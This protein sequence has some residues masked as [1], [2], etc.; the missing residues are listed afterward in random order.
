MT[1]LEDNRTIL[2]ARFVDLFWLACLLLLMFSAAIQKYTG[3][4]YVDEGVTCCLAA[5]AVYHVFSAWAHRELYVTPLAFVAAF[6]LILLAALGLFSN[7][8][9]NYNTNLFDICI[10]LFTCLKF[11]ICLLS[12]LVLFAD[13]GQTLLGWIESF[14]KPLLVVMLL[15]AIANLFF[16]FGMSGDPRYGFRASFSFI[17]GHPTSVVMLCVSLVLI[18]ARNPSKNQIYIV[19]ALIVTALT[20]RSKGFV[21]CAITP[22]V[23]HVMRDG[24]KL[25]ALHIAVCLIAAVAI[26]W[27]QFSSYYQ[28]DDAARGQLTRASIEIAQDHFPL[29]TGFGTFG[30]NISAQQGFYSPLYYQ[31]ELDGIWGLSPDNPAFLSDTFWPTVLGQFGFLGTIVY[32]TMLASSFLLLYRWGQDSR[33]SVVLCFAY[34][35]ISSTSESAFFHPMSMLPAAILGLV[36]ASSRP[37]E[38]TSSTLTGDG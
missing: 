38:D 11:P 17:C 24:R 18:L 21:F 3:F 10:D 36:V 32:A 1:T 37:A 14:A 4:S 5:A 30:S 13:N 16:N 31:Y 29:G 15:L 35:L 23:L 8:V 2:D 28:T 6:S 20:L 9:Y 19:I 33:V 34:L 12:S 22:V 7:Y 26:G 27:D 25:N